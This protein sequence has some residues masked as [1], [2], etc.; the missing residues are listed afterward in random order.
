MRESARQFYSHVCT[1]N[2]IEHAHC[3][4]L[5]LLSLFHQIL[6]LWESVCNAIEKREVALMDL[7]SFEKKASDPSRFFAKGKTIKML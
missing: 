3:P 4:L 5:L 1:A 2:T 7:E 6:N